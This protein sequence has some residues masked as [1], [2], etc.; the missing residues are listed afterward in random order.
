MPVSANNP[1]GHPATL[2]A[3]HPRPTVAFG[4]AHRIS[5]PDQDSLAALTAHL[6][7]VPRSR[8]AAE[9]GRLLTLALRVEQ[10]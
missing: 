9:L 1:A 5:M 8:R 2:R 3:G 7:G 10:G 4:S 6:S